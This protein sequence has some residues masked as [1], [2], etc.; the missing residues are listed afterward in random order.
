MYL[1]PELEEDHGIE[2]VEEALTY[3]IANSNSI[4]YPI[5]MDIPDDFNYRVYY[6]S[7][8]EDILSN[9]AYLSDNIRV[10]LNDMD[11][12]RLSI[13]HYMRVG[14]NMEPMYQYK[15]D[16]DFN[17]YMYR[18]FQ[19]NTIA[20]LT[21]EDL[22]LEYFKKKSMLEDTGELV[23]GS[24][25]D[26][27]QTISGNIDIGLDM[28]LHSLCVRDFLK[29]APASDSRALEEVT[30]AL[31]NENE[32]M[33]MPEGVSGPGFVLGRDVNVFRNKTYFTDEVYF[34]SN[35]AGVCE[36]NGDINL[37][38]EVQFE[39]N[40]TINGNLNVSGEIVIPDLIVTSNLI[41]RCNELGSNHALEREDVIDI[42]NTG[43]NEYTN[44]GEGLTVPGAYFSSNMNV[45]TKKTIFT[46]EVIFANG[47]SSFIGCESNNSNN[48]N[49]E[50]DTY[51]SITNG[52]GCNL[53]LSE[54]LSVGED[55][56]IGS[57]LSVGG[58]SY[59]GS[60]TVV[61]GNLEVHGDFLIRLDDHNP[62]SN[63]MVRE[64]LARSDENMSIET[65]L[66][67]PNV[68]FDKEITIVKGPI[69]FSDDVIFGKSMMTENCYSFD[70]EVNYHSNMYVQGEL[71]TERLNAGSITIDT[72]LFET[73][74][75][76]E[77]SN[78]VFVSSNLY[79]NDTVIVGCNIEVAG[80]VVADKLVLTDGVSLPVK[81]IDPITYD[82]LLLEVFDVENKTDIIAN[83]FDTG[84]VLP[85]AIFAEKG[86]IMSK[87]TY[88][89]SD[90][91]FAGDL[92]RQETSRFTS[93][94]F[95]GGELSV[96]RDTII[97]GELQCGSNL[98]V[99]GI[100]T[101]RDFNKDSDER[102]KCCIRNI[103][104]DLCSRFI[105][106]AR[107]K[108]YKMKDDNNSKRHYGLIAQEVEKL[109]DNITNI[110]S[111]YIPS[112]FREIKLMRGNIVFL[113]DHGMECGNRVLFQCDKYNEERVVS[114]VISLNSF[115]IDKRMSDDKKWILYG[116]YVE[117]FRSVD[118]IQI[119]SILLHEMKN[120]RKR[121]DVLEQTYA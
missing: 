64:A 85:G 78:D 96:G 58:I 106:L 47:I 46:E 13:I 97:D 43:D 101:A 1:V 112:V 121:L 18:T 52:I 84:F 28:T 98:L 15:V 60:N 56:T 35:L 110:T 41:F 118:Y 51:Y 76:I 91:F 79:V 54:W 27:L 8:N 57:N 48:N 73:A 32:L 115:R 34:G 16:D 23:I 71:F 30:L 40:V 83:V 108:E 69:Y 55:C 100:V 105:D 53:T 59:F 114:Q 94:V 61:H 17:E 4:P 66:N 87:P 49:S 26:L 104:D 116:P 113:E 2:C 92:Y 6:C 12:E 45:V 7:A 21:E 42:I 24:K 29:V 86:N 111:R 120:I 63:D 50:G 36:M 93:N 103:D 81:P 77:F 5:V 74:S 68:I 102:I 89:A 10:N 37:N 82:N 11:R 88:F 70:K 75:N 109:N 95:I 25:E 38:G 19:K 20:P 72:L 62:E 65:N 33:K 31:E 67:V 90:V 14:S 119:I 3:Y 44:F 107:V 80:T 9:V 117:D 39:S 99:D 22:Y